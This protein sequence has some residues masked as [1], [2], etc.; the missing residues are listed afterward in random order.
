MS[1]PVVICVVGDEICECVGV[2]FGQGQGGVGIPARDD[3]VVGLETGTL[4]RIHML[5]GLRHPACVR[6]RTKPV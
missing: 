5:A 2:A 1:A 4:D 6:K 3:D